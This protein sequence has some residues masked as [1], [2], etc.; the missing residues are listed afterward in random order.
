MFYEAIEVFA[1]KVLFRPKKYVQN[2]IS[3]GR[4]LEPLL[5]NV[6]KKDFLFFSHKRGAIGYPRRAIF[7]NIT[8]GK[9]TP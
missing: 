7:S 5:L 6:L 2:Q 8:T 3:L 4:S 9:F 1:G